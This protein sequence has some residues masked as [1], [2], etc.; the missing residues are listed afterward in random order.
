MKQTFYKGKI[1]QI[2]SNKFIILITKNMTEDLQNK[3]LTLLLMR[4]NLSP[5]YSLEVA[6]KW[7]ET[8][9]NYTWQNL[10]DSLKNYLVRLE[11]RELIDLYDQKIVY[12]VNDMRGLDGI[13]I[14]NRQ[15]RFKT[16]PLCFIGNE[17]VD[18]MRKRYNYSVAEAIKIGQN[19]IEE[20]IIHHVTDDH[21]FKNEHL[22]YR[23]YLDE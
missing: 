12:L 14:E 3:V 2:F 13:K 15:Y 6:K 7:L 4:F 18:W 10:Y 21:D 11:G 23:F 1:S 5:V 22:F 19:L 17:A 16:Y 8:H 9:P 20:K